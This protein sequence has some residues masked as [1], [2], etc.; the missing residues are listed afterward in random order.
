M[1]SVRRRQVGINAVVSDRQRQHRMRELRPRP[2]HRSHFTIAELLNANCGASPMSVVL[3][4]MRHVDEL[5]RD[6]ARRLSLPCWPAVSSI[7]TV[8]PVASNEM[9]FGMSSLI[10][11]RQ[12]AVQRHMVAVAVG[13]RMIWPKLIASVAEF[14]PLS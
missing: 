13:D 7:V 12:L 6:R 4:D 5:M 10:V 2:R 9:I 3:T 1:V 11:D 14:W 8:L